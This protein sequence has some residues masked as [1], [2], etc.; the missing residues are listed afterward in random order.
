[1][2]YKYKS[3]KMFTGRADTQNR[4]IPVAGN[5]YRLINALTLS[6]NSFK[7]KK[8]AQRKKIYK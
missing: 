6:N 3:T 2:H 4:L 5:N 1:M 7:K 8:K